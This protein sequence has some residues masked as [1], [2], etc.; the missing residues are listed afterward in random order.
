MLDG[1]DVFFRRVDQQIDVSRAACEAVEDDGEAV[2]QEVAGAG[3][4]E[5]SAELGQVFEFRRAWV[6]AI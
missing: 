4:V 6:A 3:F 2:D 5:S 1:P